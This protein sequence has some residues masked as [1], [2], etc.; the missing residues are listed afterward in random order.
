M[1]ISFVMPCYRSEKNIKG[2]VSEVILI[3]GQCPEGDHEVAKAVAIRW[4]L[5]M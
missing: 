1:K 2:V 4:K 5:C 3:V